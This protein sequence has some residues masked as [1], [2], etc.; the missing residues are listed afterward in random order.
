MYSSFVGNN[1][2][3]NSFYDYT[4]LLSGCSAS[5][6]IFARSSSRCS[7]NLF[8][9][10]AVSVPI[11]TKPPLACQP[12]NRDNGRLSPDVSPN[13]FCPSLPLPTV[14]YRTTRLYPDTHAIHIKLYFCASSNYW[15]LILF[16]FRQ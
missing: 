12:A 11:H 6:F 1:P 5:R 7:N 16:N 2:F 10:D 9:K 14:S 8:L 3:M 15:L 13:R 4:C